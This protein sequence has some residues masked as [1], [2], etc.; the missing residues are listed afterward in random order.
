MSRRV[1]RN[2]IIFGIGLFLYLL[3]FVLIVHLEQNVWILLLTYA[4]LAALAYFINRKNIWALQGNYFYATGHTAR[5]GPKL[6]KALEAGT[7]SP[8]AHIHYALLLVKEDKDATE[9]FVYLR[10]ALEYAKTP[11]DERNTLITMATCHYINNDPHAAIK[12]LEDMREN[13]DYVTISTLVTLGYIYL[14]VGKLDEALEVTN[15]ALEDDENY[16]SAWDNLGQI[17]FQ[18]EDFDE[19]CKAF[20]RALSLRESMADSNYFMGIICE[21]QGDKEVAAEYFRKAAISPFVY[22]NTITQEQADEKYREYFEND[23]E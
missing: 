10:R 8:S 21:Q 6:K 16:A 5:A 9:A 20:E 3:Y 4:V 19:A 14:H 17:Y 7:K 13:H 23:E 18:R 2:L 12:V 22:F 1:K 11:I 15:L